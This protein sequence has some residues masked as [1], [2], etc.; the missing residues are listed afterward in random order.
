MLRRRRLGGDHGPRAGVHAQ[1]GLDFFAAWRGYGEDRRDRAVAALVGAEVAASRRLEAIGFEKLR[2]RL[3]RTEPIAEASD[4][5][6][7]PGSS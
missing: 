6:T 7:L 3:F 4:G 5:S 2:T 1:R